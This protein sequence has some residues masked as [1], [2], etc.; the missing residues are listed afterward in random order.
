MQDKQL[1]IRTRMA[2]SPT[3]EMHVASMATLLKNY[4][5]AKRHHGQFILRIED[6][7]KTR[8]VPNGVEQIQAIIRKFGLDW[9]EGP[10]KDGPYGPYIQSQR[11]NIYQEKA[12]E[13]VAKGQAYYC[14]CSK[15][16]LEEV[17]QQQQANHQLPRYDQHCRYLSEE[18]VQKKLAAG[19]SYV[20]RLKVPANQDIV[21]TDLLR[22]E[23]SF[24][25]N[26][27]DDQVLLKSDGYPTYHL[28]VVV[29]DHLMK[30][31][32]VMRGEEWI[33]STPKHVLLYQAFGWDLP[34]FA[35]FPLFLN[36]DGKG[37]MS[38]RK[39]TVSAQSFLD[40]G[41]L[42]EALLNF[43]MILGWARKDQ[44]EI[45][46]LE[47]YIEAF[48]PRD[49]SVNSVVFDVKKLDWLNGIYI[50]KLDRPELKK[51]LQ[52]FIPPAFPHQK[53]DSILDLVYERL[54]TLAD[55]AELTDFFYKEIDYSTTTLL[56]KAQDQPGLVDE[57]IQ[58]TKR[59]IASLDV[60]DA[61]SLEKCIRQ[62][63]EKHDW[64]KGQYFMML[65]IAM[66]GRT[67]TPPLFETMAVLGKDLI[68]E[69]LDLALKRLSEN[70]K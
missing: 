13:L 20:I 5:F 40:R 25:S 44:K 16:R 46:S 23:I 21:F 31:S 37:K 8:E 7:D 15:Q 67:A 9:D 60:V 3:G 33:S 62:L 64:H 45:M 38:K 26:L 70:N 51:R 66:T 68:L 39:G 24:N 18:E 17:R 27:V 65:R 61:N 69:R 2:P 43:L 49:L 19:E 47:E 53:I 28:A 58:E 10:G 50:R 42:P 4:A 52:P 14:F 29:D 32:H 30:I 11:I 12:Q 22:G 34:I 57:Q 36:P 1:P 55:F 54:V 63:Q 56:K 48:D 41:Y 35:H 59:V 6:T